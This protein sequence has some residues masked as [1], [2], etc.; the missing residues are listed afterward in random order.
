MSGYADHSDALDPKYGDPFPV[1]IVMATEETLK[2]Y[3]TIVTNFDETKVEIT[4]WPVKGK[5]F[6]RIF[7]LQNLLY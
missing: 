4:P 3:G 6:S 2:G 5:P 7:M 1:P